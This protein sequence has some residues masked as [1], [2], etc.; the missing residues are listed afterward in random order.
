MRSAPLCFCQQGMTGRARVKAITAI[1]V[2]RVKPDIIYVCVPGIRQLARCAVFVQHIAQD[3][4]IGITDD[5]VKFFPA[6][7]VDTVA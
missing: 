7:A 1:H 6:P 3:R 5:V 4:V 2:L